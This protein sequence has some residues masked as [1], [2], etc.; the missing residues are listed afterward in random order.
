[1]SLWDDDQSAT[2]EFQNLYLSDPEKGLA[3]IAS[4]LHFEH[5]HEKARQVRT[6]D[7]L[8]DFRLLNSVRTLALSNEVA[9]SVQ[10]NKLSDK[11]EQDKRL[12]LLSDKTII[13]I[14]GKFSAGKSKFINALLNDDILPEDQRPTTSIPTYILNS[15][16]NSIFAYTTNNQE[17][18]L[19][20]EAMQAL[21]HEFHDKYG[22]GFSQF[23]RN[24]VVKNRSIENR[25]IAILDTPGYSKYDSDAKKTI[26]DE[27]KAF[28][29]L[30]SSDYLIWLIDIEN[31][32]IQ[33]KDIEFIRSLEMQMPVL[34]VFN[35]ADKKTESDAK[36]IIKKSNEILIKNEINVYG[37][38]AYSSIYS[39]EYYGTNYISEFLK[40]ASEYS[41][42]NEDISKQL[43]NVISSLERTFGELEQR[44]ENERNF[45][46]DSIYKSE[47]ILSIHCLVELYAD[48]FE[49]LNLVKACRKDLGSVSKDINKSL[50]NLI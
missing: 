6:L 19:D 13:G 37:I 36:D 41:D 18:E 30:K 24:L 48:S 1:M 29:Q 2:H 45:L 39:T 27:H 50:R 33:N 11:I 21:T 26:S 46:G 35:K 42:R 9:L 5:D 34:I 23:V 47:D 12:K 3:L 43:R 7:Y 16:Q 17:I 22:L 44:A 4:L 31:G 14:G 38:S 15:D 32:V 40:G 20:L 49:Q 10:L 25:N 28:D 8:I